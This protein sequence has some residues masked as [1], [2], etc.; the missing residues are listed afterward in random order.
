[1][2]AGFAI[3]TVLVV[4]GSAN[5]AQAQAVDLTNL[6]STLST[7]TQTL[8][9]QLKQGIEVGAPSGAEVGACKLNVSDLWKIYNA[10]TMAGKKGGRGHPRSPNEQAFTDDYNSRPP[11]GQKTLADEERRYY[12][13]SYY[14]APHASDDPKASPQSRILNLPNIVTLPQNT[15]DFCKIP[16]WTKVKA[17]LPFNPTYETNVLKSNLGDSPGT[18]LGLGGTLLVTAS[19]GLANRPY[20]LI[21]FSAQSTSVRY[22][23]FPAKSVDAFT[24]QGAYQFL[25]GADGYRFRRID[26][27]GNYTRI[28]TDLSSENVGPSCETPGLSPQQTR[29]CAD[30]AKAKVDELTKAM[31]AASMITADTLALG[32]Q[33]QTAYTPTFRHET[34][35]LF[36]PQATLARSNMPLFY[37]DGAEPCVAVALDQ[38]QQPDKTKYGYCYYADFSLT[39]GQTFSERITQENTNVAASATLGKRFDR[40]DFKLALQTTLTEKTFEYVKGGRQDVLLQSGPTL[41][42]TPAPVSSPFGSSAATFSLAVAYNQ[43]FSTLSAASWRGVIVQPTLTIAFQPPASLPADHR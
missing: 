5:E 41:T 23:A 28:K 19:T 22:S 32:Y 35:D 3:A 16:Q 39:V 36:T 30:D 15:P 34:A 43:N 13:D 20:D 12:L 21:A 26:P 4:L 9:D 38:G 37:S 6:Q 17:S 31:P 8:A 18:S 25:L 14:G 11:T 42:Y 24:T 27:D 10:N 7:F 40:T 33:N 1:L 29:K 2:A